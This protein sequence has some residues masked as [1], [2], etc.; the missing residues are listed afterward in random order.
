MGFLAKATALFVGLRVGVSFHQA[1]QVPDE[2]QASLVN[3][4]QQIRSAIRNAA[5]ALRMAD[6]LWESSHAALR[7]DS[8]QRIVEPKFRTQG[9]FA[10]KLLVDPSSKPPQQIDLD[11]GLYVLVDFLQDGRPALVAGALFTAVEQVLAPVCSRNGWKLVTDKSTCVRVEVSRDAHIDIPIYSAPREAFHSALLEKATASLSDGRSVTAGANRQYARLPADKIML[12]HRDGTWQE[13]DPLKLHDWVEGCVTRYGE[14]FRRACRYLKGWRD[15]TWGGKCCLSSI[16]LMVAVADA[17]RRMQG[18]HRNYDDDRLVYEVAQMLPDILGDKIANPVVHGA[19]LNDWD[20]DQRDEV[21][22][23][24]RKFAQS[25][26][27]ALTQRFDASHVVAALRAAFGPRMPNR[28]DMVEILPQ[29]TAAVFTS[30][31]A[32]VP[33][34]KVTNSTSG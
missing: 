2:K 34:P 28:P 8:Q 21:L 11:D 23:E 16:T 24:A 1:L 22:R 20:A 3:A 29:A 12:A 19:V 30:K 27:D 14:D 25:M 33:S 17:L 15:Y 26:A 13:S 5:S 4:R 7:R 31:P 9:S 6:N 32:T 10:Y 18:Q